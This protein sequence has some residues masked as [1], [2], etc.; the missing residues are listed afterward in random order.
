V[1]Q[2]GRAHGWHLRGLDG[3][4]V[5]G[6]E[7]VVRR[8]AWRPEGNMLHL[9]CQGLHGGLAAHARLE[10]P[11]GYIVRMCATMRAATLCRSNA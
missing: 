9:R 8:S 5:A 7:D 2:Q 10:C 3:S 6:D 1:T 11:Y 4:A